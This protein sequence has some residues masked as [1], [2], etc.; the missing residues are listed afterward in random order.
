M[1]FTILDILAN[2][3]LQEQEISYALQSPS[4]FSG[5]RVFPHM[6]ACTAFSS[7]LLLLVPR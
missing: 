5:L 2:V 4:A 1:I 7:A 3:F 6:H